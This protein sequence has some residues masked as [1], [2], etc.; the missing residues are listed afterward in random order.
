MRHVLGCIIILLA[1]YVTVIMAI[2]GFPCSP[3]GSCGCVYKN[4]HGD[5]LEI[6]MSA[7]NNKDGTA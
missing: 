2:R 6:S 5:Q 1:H 4:E 3:K 7:L